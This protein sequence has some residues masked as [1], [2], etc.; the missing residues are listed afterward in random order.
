MI[1]FD[2]E[3]CGL[4]GPIV[5]IQYAHDNDET[6]IHHV[7]ESSALDTMKI[8]EE[9]ADN[10]VCGFN[11]T[12]D[13]F[14]VQ[15][16][17]NVLCL[18]EDVHTP[19][20]DL[21][22]D[23][24]LLEPKARDGLCIKPK[25]ALDLMLHARKGPYQST[26][27]R[28]PIKIRRIPTQIAWQLAEEL[29]NSIKFDSIYFA[30][31][32]KKT[33]AWRVADITEEDGT[34]NPN[35]KNIILDFKPS[36]ALKVLATHALGLETQKYADIEPPGYP[37][38]YGYAPFALA[39]GDITNWNLAWPQY[40]S[41]HMYHWKFNPLAIKYATND[42]IFLQKLY[43]HFGC[44]PHSDNDSLLACMVGSCRWRGYAIDIEYMKQQKIEL[45]KMVAETPMAPRVV[46]RYLNQVLSPTEQAI[47]KGSTKKTILEELT[48][49]QI[50]CPDCNGEGCDKC[51]N[52]G[53]PHPVA[54]RAD[55]VLKARIA[56]RT[57]DFYDKLIRAGRFHASFK[58]I[59]TKSSRMS[60]ADDLNAQ[61]IPHDKKVRKC[62]TLALPGFV[63]TGGDFE[64]FEVCLADAVYNDPRLR[65]D[66]LTGKKIH[67]L[68]AEEL[69]PGVTYD[70]INASKGKN[71][72]YYDKGKRSVFAIIYGGDENTLKVK[73][74]VPLEIAAKAVQGFMTKYRQVG[75]ER[76]KVFDKFCS[77]R[78]PNGIG[79]RVEWHDPSDYIESIDG[80]RRYFT[81]ENVTCK[82]LFQL[83]NK[84]PESLKNIKLKVVRRDKEQT[85]S[86]AIQ[87]A[88]YGAAFQIQ[89]ANM[90]AAANHVIQCSGAIITKDLQRRLWDL[91]PSGV[92]PWVIQPMNVH[93]EILCPCFP[94]Y[95]HKIRGVVDN[96]IKETQPKVP[97]IGID[98]H[99]F[100]NS[101]AEK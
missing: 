13:W 43:E 76:K 27:N 49:L 96:F 29:D 16:M 21:I 88:L 66:L 82:T 70:E 35:F 85:V 46:K 38:E 81:L 17:Y 34:I 15:Q 36:S 26:M 59:G 90:R 41:E 23:Y 75:V 47:M 64:S 63:L 73:V 6:K 2:T 65:Q 94:G 68:F 44:P 57:I 8:L 95:E 60:G 25:G 28:A 45:E 67:A 31:S 52:G 87:S 48:Q 89:A 100:M 18:I 5:T 33:G 22:D 12:Y 19:L 32:K 101:W 79:T 69:F 40:I 30:R 39:V 74:G 50:D 10:V 58:V 71:P 92:T 42:V 14:H 84:L 37:K 61:G 9:L 24:A 91:Q 80:F 20:I 77:M 93:D 11:L 56:T 97:L 99:D 78:Q 55:R 53:I 62:F 98:W 7:W 3:T 54:E 72:D 4:T 83:A 1:F 51:D 86:G